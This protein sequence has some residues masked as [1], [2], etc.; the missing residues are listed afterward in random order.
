MLKVKSGKL[1]V[2][3]LKGTECAQSPAPAAGVG[4]E[5]RIYGSKGVGL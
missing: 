3:T 5:Q 4:A 2:R 1:L